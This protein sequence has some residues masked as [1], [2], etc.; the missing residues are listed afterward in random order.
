MYVDRDWVAQAQAALKCPATESVLNS[1]R[2]PLTARRFLSNVVHAYE[3]TQYRLERVP[4]YELI[5]C[6]LPIPEPHEPPY[7]GMPAAGP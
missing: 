7:T 3:F 2:A 5:R 1:I 4:R 6:G